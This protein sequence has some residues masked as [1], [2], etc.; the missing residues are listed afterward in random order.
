MVLHGSKKWRV[1]VEWCG[2]ADLADHRWALTVISKN[3]TQRSKKALWSAPW[4]E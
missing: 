1:A 2:Q 3:P 4:R